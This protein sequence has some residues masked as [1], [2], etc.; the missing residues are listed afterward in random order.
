V[1]AAKIAKKRKLD[2][3]EQR[4]GENSEKKWAKEKQR[5]GLGNN[6]LETPMSKCRSRGG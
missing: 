6:G 1:K 4:L 5:V 3:S 2:E